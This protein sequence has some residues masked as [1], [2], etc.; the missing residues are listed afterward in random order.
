MVFWELI[1]LTPYHSFFLGGKVLTS[2]E[3]G[4]KDNNLRLSGFYIQPQ[5]WIHVDVCSGKFLGFQQDNM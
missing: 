1:A 4:V 3:G 5:I 2:F